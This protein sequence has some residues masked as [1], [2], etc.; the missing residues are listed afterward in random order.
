M[1]A[2]PLI[3]TALKQAAAAAAHHTGIRRALALTRRIACGGRRVLIL[4]Y[5]RVVADLERERDRSIPAGLI[6]AHTFQRQLCA[7]S[8]A[9]YEFASMSEAV[10]VLTR[11]RTAKKDLCVVTFDDGYRDVY[12]FA[13]PLL[14]SKGIPAI[15]YLPAALIGTTRRLDHDRLFHLVSLAG[16]A[17]FKP[18]V[19]ELPA[20][21]ATLLRLAAEGERRVPAALDDGISQA[22][23]QALRAAIDALANRLGV[24]A[25]PEWGDLID[26]DEAR[27][28]A[29]AGYELGAHTLEHVVLTLEGPAR[30]ER[31]MRGSKE[32][33]ERQIGSPVR[34]FSYCNGWYSD[35]LIRC[36]SRLGFESAVTT[37]DYPN[38]VGDSPFALK[39]KMLWENFSTGVFGGYSAALTSCCIDD[40][41]GMLGLA[42]PVPG[43]RSQ[44]FGVDPQWELFDRKPTAPSFDTGGTLPCGVEGETA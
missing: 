44:R 12:R 27:R 1:L 3:R 40:V 34:H 38:R 41:F 25:E 36:V 20:P 2:T 30:I 33:I 37:E 31:E 35:R 39:R 13:F 9:G 15:F 21:A 16:R 4:G 6:S 43:K 11:K 29:A 28:M 10:E 42:H 8:R 23:S 26:W 18:K 22:P 17:G 32:R 7:A 5:H 19:D 14:R 24:P